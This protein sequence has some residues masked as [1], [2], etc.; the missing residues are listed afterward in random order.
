MRQSV[1]IAHDEDLG[2]DTALTSH[3]LFWIGVLLGCTFSNSKYC[4]VHTLLLD[5]SLTCEALRSPGLS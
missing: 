2:F 1:L 4:V 3:F 5:W